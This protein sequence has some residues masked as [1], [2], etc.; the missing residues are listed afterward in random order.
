MAGAEPQSKD[1]A[2]P[3]GGMQASLLSLDWVYWTREKKI[4]IS[5]Q[6]LISF[7][8]ITFA[9]PHPRAYSHA[10]SSSCS[11][12]L[13]ESDVLI[14]NCFSLLLPSYCF[15]SFICNTLRIEKNCLKCKCGW[16]LDS[17]CSFPTTTLLS[18]IQTQKKFKAEMSETDITKKSLRRWWG[19]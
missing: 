10:L 8:L 15:C 14:S 16:A 19:G 9:L 4:N 3:T 7:L 11:S 13:S 18:C 5:S 12:W 2:V 1:L 17:V 6:M